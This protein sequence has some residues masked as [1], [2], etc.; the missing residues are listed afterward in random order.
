MRRIARSITLAAATFAVA[1]CQADRTTPTAPSSDAELWTPRVPKALVLGACV[2]QTQL[3]MKADVVFGGG[4]PNS[5]SVKSKI[6]QIE[7]ANKKNDRKKAT[8]AA[9]NAVRFVFQKFKGPQPLAGTPEQVAELITQIFCFAGLDIVVDDP[10]NANLIDPSSQTQ[11]V[12]S[13]DNT[14][15]TSLPPNAITEPTILEFKKLPNAQTLTRLDQYPG[16]FSVTA[17]SASNSGPAAPVVVAICPAAGIPADVRARLRL[18]HQKTSGFEITPPADASFLS[19]PVGTASASSLPRWLGKALSLVMPKSLHAA[20]EPMFFGGVGGTASEFSPFA[21]VD[22]ELSFAG[23]V[24]GTAGE[25]K[26]SGPTKPGVTAPG[27]TRTFGGT[28]PNIALAPGMVANIAAP[29]PCAVVEAVWGTQLGQE[30]RPGIVVRTNNGTLMR[31]V[32]VAFAVTGGGGAIAAEDPIS[33]ACVGTPGTSVTVATAGSAAGADSGRAGVCWTMGPTPG[34]NTASATP[35]AGGDAPDGVIFTPSSADFSA[36]AIKATPDVAVSCP[37]SVTYNGANQTPCTAAATD[38]EHGDSALGP[39]P[40]SYGPT[41]PP[42]DAG[43]YTADA[44]FAATT[45]YNAATAGST[46]DIVKAATTTVVTCSAASFAYTGSAIT[47]CSANVTGPGGL[48]QAV[49]PVSYAN[50]VNPGTATAT[51]TYPASAN[52]LTSTGS[53]TF[54]IADPVTTWSATGPAGLTLGNDGSTGIPS[55]SYAVFLGNPAGGVSLRTW[56]FSTTAAFAGTI[57]QSY[58]YY[59]FHAFYAVTVFVKPF[60]IHNGITTYLPGI[61]QGPINCCT[62]PSAGFTLT[63]SATFT[64]AAGDTYG[65]EIGG[66]NGDSNSTLNGTFV[67]ARDPLYVNHLYD[68]DGYNGH[69]C[70]HDVTISVVNATTL[71]WTNGCAPTPVSWLMHAT[72]NPAFYTSGPDY[73]YYGTGADVGFTL[74]FGAGGI[75]QSTTGPSGELYTRVP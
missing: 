44:S 21:P 63:G 48:N 40:V 57:K 15:G 47:P 46:F 2:T 72:G 10:F 30:C 64:V 19:C 73:P 42:K 29:P 39:V 20:A 16:F 66:S 32:P 7:K 8:E 43:A 3:N 71:R 60:V 1:A 75:I 53:E 33:K 27:P 51:A 23:G 14:A 67:T 4:G 18:G 17:S 65:F 31:G 50:N 11:I 13:S 37:A 35:S 55:M 54:T 12:T 68:R 45:H 49:T 38:P 69:N 26:K 22:I 59:G 70:Y 36:E 52:Y 6:E 58:S 25:F 9:F 61:N 56:T 24:G 5:N 74:T 28:M 34:T 62:A 41:T